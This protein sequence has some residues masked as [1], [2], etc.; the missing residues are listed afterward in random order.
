MLI[1]NRDQLCKWSPRCYQPNS[2][3][4]PSTFLEVK[5]IFESYGLLNLSNLGSLKETTGLRECNAM[6]TTRTFML[7]LGLFM[8]EWLIVIILK[9]IPFV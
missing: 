1:Q 3:L 7:C 8:I 6:S 2:F 9:F 5:Q 4:E